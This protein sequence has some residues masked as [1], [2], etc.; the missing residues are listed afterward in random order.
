MPARSSTTL[1]DS[2]ILV[3]AKRKTSRPRI[4]IRL[5]R[6]SR[7][8]WVSAPV[9]VP[10]AGISMAEGLEPSEP[11]SAARNESTA[12]ASSTTAPAPSPNSTAVVRSS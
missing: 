12:L 9:T 5:R 10:P 4:E 11:S 6:A 1:V 8:A 7:S 2:I 3:T